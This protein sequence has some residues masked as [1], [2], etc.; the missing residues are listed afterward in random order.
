MT[1]QEKLTLQ[2][3]DCKNCYLFKEGMF[4][5]VYNEGAFMFQE[6]SKYKVNAKYLKVVNTTVYSMGFPQSVLNRFRIQ[7]K[8]SDIDDK[9]L[10]FSINNVNFE[11]DK[12]EQWCRTFV[13]N[14]MKSTTCILNQIKEYPL[15]SKTPIEVYMWLYQLQKQL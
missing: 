4:Y 5:K 7:Y 14:E 13:A 8:I 15:A 2:S 6:I 1:I 11:H 9:I 3:N 12:Y 10:K